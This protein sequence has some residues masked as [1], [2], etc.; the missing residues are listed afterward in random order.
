MSDKV[1][2]IRLS[3]SS[4]DVFHECERKWQLEKLLIDPSVREENEHT[5][6]GRAL[7][8]GAAT[9]LTTQDTD[10]ALYQ[11]W[12][13]YWP[14]LESDKKNIPLC[15]S[16]LLNMFPR[17]DT[18]LMDYEVATF[19]GRPAV[20]LSF[21]LDISDEYYFVGYIDVVLRHRISGVYSVFDVKSTGL[22]LYDL[23]P[24][25]QN[26]GQVL[27]YSVALDRIVGHELGSYGVGYVV[28]QVNAGKLTSKTHVLTY[29]KTILDR[30]QW[31]MILGLD[32][33]RMES[34][35]E[36]NYYP[37]RG[38]SCLSYNRPCRYF[39]TCTLQSLDLPRKREEDLIQY[40]FRYS[41]NELIQDH[42]NR[43]PAEKLV[44][45]V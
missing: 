23:A 27:G 42:M 36:L 21:R 25:Y 15:I 43:I 31:F 7:G 35:S 4:L 11:A 17:L 30:L 9:Y 6:F 34:M 39:G 37:R 28:A 19:K 29:E 12:L 5:V 1:I 41:L 26:S 33:K 18:L 10:M 8:A 22:Q 44:E 2:P 13:T 24:L 16:A 40:D 3:H 14:E 20:E 45:L 32:V 38:G